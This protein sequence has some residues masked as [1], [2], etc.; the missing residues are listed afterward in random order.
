[1]S[2]YLVCKNEFTFLYIELC[3]ASA[4]ILPG[5]SYTPSITPE[6]GQVGQNMSQ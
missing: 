2:Y 4:S 6:C 1:M 3:I 5:I